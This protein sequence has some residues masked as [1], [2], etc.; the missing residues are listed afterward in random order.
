M[1]KL[2]KRLTYKFY[3][4][5]VGGSILFSENKLHRSKRSMS[6]KMPY[7]LSKSINI[8]NNPY[9]IIDM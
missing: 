5:M 4:K 3:S 8:L 2:E 1:L 6:G 9:K 7:L